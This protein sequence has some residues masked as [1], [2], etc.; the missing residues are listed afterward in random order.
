MNDC[1]FCAIVARH[2]LAASVYADNATLAF[3]DIH[4]VAEGHTL[5]IPRAHIR[6]LFDLDDQTGMAIMHTI[7]VV[8]NA[9]RAAGLAEGL[10]LLQSNA[11]VGGQDI[12]HLHFHLIPRKAND[13]IM[14][15]RDH[16]RIFNWIVLRE[17]PMPELM[18]TAD[19]IRA[20]IARDWPDRS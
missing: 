4:P 15:R 12:F 3:L 6:T 2:S 17:P 20:L 5:V 14:L 18:Q 19:A 13:G 8:A 16:D 1:L 10:N 9:L 7:R 11:F